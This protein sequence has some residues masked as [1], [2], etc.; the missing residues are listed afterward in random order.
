MLRDYLNDNIINEKS[1][2]RL[3]RKFEEF[4]SGAITAFRG[5]FSSK[6][7]KARNKILI[8]KL[9]TLGY[10][11]VSVKGTYIEDFGSESEHE[12]SENSFIVT[13]RKGT[14]DTLEKN[15]SK[16]GHLFDQD[17]VLII[18]PG[19]SPYLLGTSKRPNAWPNFGKK[20]SL[21]G[22]KGGK[23]KQFFSRVKGRKFTFEEIEII[24]Q[25]TTINGRWGLHILSEKRWQDIVD[26]V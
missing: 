13:D 5:E 12:V 10:D 3:Y 16:L 2:S 24:Q 22:F 1:L 8:S 15:L 25:P 19:S 21:G 20:E 14:I 17:S 4:P 7:N 11:V 9:L 26:I 23:G 18:P 6:E